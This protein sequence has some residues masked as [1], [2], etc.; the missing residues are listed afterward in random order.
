MEVTFLCE[1]KYAGKAHEKADPLPS[2][3]P[4]PECPTYQCRPQ[5]HHG[6]GSSGDSGAD[7]LILSHRH[8]GH[9]ADEQQDANPRGIP[10]L[11]SGRLAT[12]RLRKT[13]YIAPPATRKRRPLRMNGG[14]PSSPNFSARYVDPHTKYTSTS[15]SAIAARFPP[16]ADLP[17][18][19]DEHRL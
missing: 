2:N 18:A 9:A 10:P 17:A 19:L 14:K 16:H 13:R 6:D 3:G 1:H 11:L 4:V 7:A 8:E 15:A 5:R 12:P